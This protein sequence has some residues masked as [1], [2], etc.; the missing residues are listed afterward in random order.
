MFDHKKYT[1]I[2]Q[3]HN[4]IEHFDYNPS[5]DWAIELIQNGLDSENILIVASFSKPVDKHEIKPYIS[6]ALK[7]L[8]LIEKY[9]E[10]SIIAN[11]HYYLDQILNDFEIRKNLTKIYHLCLNA[12]YEKRLMPFYLL[13]HGWDELEQ[14]GA[15]Y[16]FEGAN[17]D[18]MEEVIKEQA[19]I[20]IDKYI[21]GKDEVINPKEAPKISQPLAKVENKKS[22]WQRVNNLWRNQ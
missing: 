22:F 12:N 3:W 10:Y 7:E 4:G 1:K 15:N 2:L 19:Q 17:L 11:T 21:H 20:W 16:Y 6:G 9:G 8:N 14:I 13:Y 5:I 18:N